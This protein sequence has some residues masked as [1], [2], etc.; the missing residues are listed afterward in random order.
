MAVGDLRELN[1]T[2]LMLLACA[3]LTFG[4]LAG[5]CDA[6]VGSPLRFTGGE[7]TAAV[8][9]TADGVYVLM[10]LGRTFIVTPPQVDWIKL[11]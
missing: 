5:A 7:G 8:V 1:T 2:C 9:R 4:A 3:T 6:T 10:R 11:K